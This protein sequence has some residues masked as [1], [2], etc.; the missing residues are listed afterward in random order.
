MWMVVAKHG[1]GARR[2]VV[3][4]QKMLADYDNEIGYIQ[5]SQLDGEILRSSSY[6]M[7]GELPRALGK[8]IALTE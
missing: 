1:W 6:L 3:Y 8:C 2:Y 4:Q 5:T 7:L